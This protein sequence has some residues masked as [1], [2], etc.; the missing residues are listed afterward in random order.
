MRDPWH[1]ERT[2]YHKATSSAMNALGES[3]VIGYT[4]HK[5]ERTLNDHTKSS[6]GCIYSAVYMKYDYVYSEFAIS[7]ISVL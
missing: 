4:T 3:T 1:H 2:L 5:P 7:S 6:S